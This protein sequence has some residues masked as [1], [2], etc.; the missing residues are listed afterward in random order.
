M[1]K[2]ILMFGKGVSHE[3][4]NVFICCSMAGFDISRNRNS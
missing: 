2:F 4:K 1:Q 3:S